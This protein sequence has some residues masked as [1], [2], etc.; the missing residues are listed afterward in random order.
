M[1]DPLDAAPDMVPFVTGAELG[2]KVR[3]EETRL[4]LKALL[5]SRRLTARELEGLILNDLAAALA[6]RLRISE[7][8]ALEEIGEALGLTWRW[9]LE[10]RPG[11]TEPVG[12]LTMDQDKPKSPAESKAEREQRLRERERR[13]WARRRRAKR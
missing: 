13:E 4:R 1:S 12:I 9:I 3:L 5:D 11:A 7:R 2:Q 8:E 6:I 10:G